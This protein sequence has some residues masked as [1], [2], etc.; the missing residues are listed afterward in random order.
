MILNAQGPDSLAVRTNKSAQTGMYRAAI[1]PVQV[2]PCSPF[3]QMQN[4]GTEGSVRWPQGNYQITNVRVGNFQS[5]FQ[6]GDRPGFSNGQGYLGPASVGNRSI[7]PACNLQPGSTNWRGKFHSSAGVHASVSVK[8]A[9]SIF[10]VLSSSQ[11]NSVA[12]VPKSIADFHPSE[13]RIHRKH[14]GHDA[15][16][17]WTGAGRAAETLGVIAGRVPIVQTSPV[18]PIGPR[19]IRRPY[20]GS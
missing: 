11:I 4:D 15:G 14:Q 9:V 2:P 20:P 12:R 1:C 16:D 17:T 8:D 3:A 19:A 5:D 13:S 18:I 6:N 10:V 7:E